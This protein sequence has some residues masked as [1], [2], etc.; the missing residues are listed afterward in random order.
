[1]CCLALTDVNRA[2]A[3]GKQSSK[4][5]SGKYARSAGSRLRRYNEAALEKDI[6]QLLQEWAA[7]LAAAQYIFLHAPG[8]NSRVLV[9]SKEASRAAAVTGRG[10]QGH[11]LDPLDQRLRFVPFMTKRPTFSELRRVFLLLGSVMEAQVEDALGQAAEGSAAAK[12]EAQEQQ[13]QQGAN[14]SSSSS[15]T[16][17]PVPASSGAAAGAADALDREAEDY[18]AGLPGGPSSGSKSKKQV[19]AVNG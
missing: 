3:G 14:K 7:H 19:S 13:L 16:K 9:N 18:L 10:L 6:M 5:A 12:A 2:K 11:L 17:E 8:S 4:D 1:M 15:P